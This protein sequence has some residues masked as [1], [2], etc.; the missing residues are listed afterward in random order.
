[1][2]NLRTVLK[3]AAG[4]ALAAALIVTPA[5]GQA[6]VDF[7]G[8]KV[9]LIVPFNEGGGADVYARLM[10]PFLQKYL[11]G[12]PTVI[13]RNEPGGGGVKS[14]NKFQKAKGDGLTAMTISTSNLI[15]FALGSSKVKY[16]VLSWR[17]VVLSP[18]GSIFYARPETGVKGEDIAADVQALRSFDMVFGAKNATASEMRAVLA[19]ELLGIKNVNVVFGLSSG[20]QRKAVFRNE[21]NINYDSAN[22]YYTKVD[23]FSKEGKVVPF[24]TMGVAKADG[25]IVR[26]PAAPDLP[27]WS[28]AF[29]AINGTQPQGVVADAY[30][31]FL[32]MGVSAS[33]AIVLPGGTSDE[34]QAAWVDAMVKIQ[35]DPEFMKLAEKAIGVYT[36]YIG[37][38]ATKVLRAATDVKPATRA[39]LKNFIKQRFGVDI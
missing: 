38:D 37:D 5:V 27:T 12:S 33:K 36:Q 10:Q 35:E 7:A 17:P 9:T 13:V 22:A 14:C 8:K 2:R 11:P 31:N 30:L 1:M 25:T 3:H 29:A 6:A 4:T 15:P 23:R 18:Q 34:V 20:Q 28:E 39:W 21:L 24:V 32:H 16:D 19:F 26:D